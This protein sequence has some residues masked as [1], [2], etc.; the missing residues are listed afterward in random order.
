ML[1]LF[2]RLLHFRFIFLLFLSLSPPRVSPSSTNWCDSAVCSFSSLC[3]DSL[4]FHRIP[5]SSSQSQGIS[6][7]V[8]LIFLLDSSQVI[9]ACVKRASSRA[10]SIA[11]NTA[12]QRGEWYARAEEEKREEADERGER[13]EREG[14]LNPHWMVDVQS[15]FFQFSLARQPGDWYRSRFGVL[16]PFLLATAAAAG[17][18]SR[19]SFS[20]NSWVE[21]VESVDLVC[22][23]LCVCRFICTYRYIYACVYI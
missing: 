15:Y 11:H 18:W 17:D 3:A 16:L 23:F 9:F 12:A 13:R 6:W 19:V 21:W 5:R 2:T 22:M 14:E 1:L 8:S 7:C 20:I 10:T 4:L